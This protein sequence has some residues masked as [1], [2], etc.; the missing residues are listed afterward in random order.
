MLFFKNFA[1]QQHDK[2]IHKSIHADF[3]Y[4]SIKGW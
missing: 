3:C 2:G 1:H 4:N